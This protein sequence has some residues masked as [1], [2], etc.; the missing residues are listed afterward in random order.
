MNA[1][2]CDAVDM[3]RLKH[4]QRTD[5]TSIDV[6]K[7]IVCLN[8]SQYMYLGQ[9]FEQFSIGAHQKEMMEKRYE[10]LYLALCPELTNQLVIDL[11][12]CLKDDKVQVMDNMGGALDIPIREE[13]SDRR[14][15]VN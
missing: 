11:K 8:Y 15:L 12:A 4:Q 10:E 7:I 6:S 9:L 1:I 2:A 5:S 13:Q 3:D 14:S